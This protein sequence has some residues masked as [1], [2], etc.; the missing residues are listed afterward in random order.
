MDTENHM[1][2]PEILKLLPEMQEISKKHE[3]IKK[4]FSDID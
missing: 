4:I 1:T 2:N 3:K